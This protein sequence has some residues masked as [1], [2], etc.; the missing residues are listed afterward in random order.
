VTKEDL[1]IKEFYSLN[2]GK[3]QV[4]SRV[5][6]TQVIVPE[7]VPPEI[8]LKLHLHPEDINDKQYLNVTFN[9]VREFRLCQPAWS[10]FTI[11][12]LNIVSIADN[13]WENLNYKITDVEDESLSFFCNKFA[14]YLG[15]M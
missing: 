13:Q 4:V 5:E 8:I 14:A 6:I 10:L 7:P 9:G 11:A 3:F 12:Q 1:A 15:I 2:P